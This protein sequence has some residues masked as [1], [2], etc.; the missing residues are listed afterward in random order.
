FHRVGMKAIPMRADTGPIG[1]DLSH[2]FIILADTGESA[3]F[4]HRDFL[5]LEVPPESVDFRDDAGI[6][7]LVEQWTTPYAAT[8]EM[9]DEKAW[10]AIVPGDR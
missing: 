5:S 10:A 2:E 6:A 4:C 8:D 3:V 1:G 9:H 7:A